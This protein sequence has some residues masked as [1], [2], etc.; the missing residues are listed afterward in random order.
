MTACTILQTVPHPVYDIDL[1]AL[2]TPSG[3]TAI[4]QALKVADF[5]YSFV[6]HDTIIKHGLSIRSVSSILGDRGYRQAGHLAGWGRHQLT[7]PNGANMRQISEHHFEK[8]SQRLNRDGMHLIIYDLSNVAS[9]SASDPYLH[10]KQ[11]ERQLIKAHQNKYNCTPIGNVKDEAYIDSK[12][13][14]SAAMLDSLFEFN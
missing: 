13:Y 6:F 8:T 10:V 5:V 9:P 7:G 12:T 3:I 2:H 4:M 14:V 1:A 11:L